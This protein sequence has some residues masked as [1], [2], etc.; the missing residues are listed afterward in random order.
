MIL[1]NS[2][3]YAKRDSHQYNIKVDQF[4]YMKIKVITTVVLFY[5]LCSNWFMFVYRFFF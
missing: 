2:L 1:R 5:S 3:K 4:K